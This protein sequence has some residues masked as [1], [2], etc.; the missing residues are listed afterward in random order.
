MSSSTS[1]TAASKTPGIVTAAFILSCLGFCGITAIVGIVL[2]FVGRGQA[3]R[4]GKGEGLA[5]AAIII[6]AAWL[7]IAVIGG[8]VSAG[9][10]GTSSSQSSSPQSTVSTPSAEALPASAAP[11][12]SLA[13]EVPIEE[14]PAEEPAAPEETVSQ[15]NAREKAKSYLDFQAF[16]RKGLNEQLQFEGFSKDDAAYGV[17]ALNVDWDQQ[18]AL[19]AKSYLDFQAFSRKGLIEQLKFEGFTTEQATYGVNANGL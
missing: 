17:D 15:A 10:G 1:S 4:A 12:P 8:I 5:L 9:S 2:G 7:V 13:S 19:K 14:A 18:A 6:G 11:A 3:K 16:S